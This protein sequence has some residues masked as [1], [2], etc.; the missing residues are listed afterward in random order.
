M[1]S[2]H[3]VSL[4]PCV[5]QLLLVCDLNL[6]I[7]IIDQYDY[8]YLRMYTCFLFNHSYIFCLVYTFK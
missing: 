4:T 3:C 7:I 6:Q 8:L 5:F 2:C 1:N